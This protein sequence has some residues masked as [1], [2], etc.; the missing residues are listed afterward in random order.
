MPEPM[1]RP[2]PSKRNGSRRRGLAIIGAIVLLGA[3]GYAVYWFL[4]LAHYEST[5]DAYVS[6]DVLTVTPLEDGTVQAVHVDDTQR[7]KRGQLLVELDDARPKIEM[8]AARANL[9][10]TVRD[11]R[12]TFAKAD[13]LR[14]LIKQRQVQVDRAQA[15]YK[16]RADL[17]ADGAVAGEDIA[18]AKDDLAELKAQLAVAREQLNSTLAQL[19]GTGVADNPQVLAAASRVRDAALSLA[20]MRIIAP[21]DGTVAQRSVEIGQHV[22]AGEP[23]MAVVPLQSVWVDANFKE[24]Q[25]AD[26][27]VGQPVELESDVYGGDVTFHGRVAGFSAGSGSAFALLPPQNASG[28]WIKIVQRLP[29]RIALDPKEVEKHPLRIGLSMSANVDVAD[30]SGPVISDRVRDGTPEIKPRDALAPDVEAMI[31]ETIS[32]NAGDGPH[33]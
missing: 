16:R 17:G 30:T 20:H 12:A 25:L 6:G 4:F 2:A 31:A 9:A 11:V 21:V 15:D 10:R 33:K 29:V 19:G 23:L 7:V 1:D 3:I 13:E 5:N 22:K 8:E 24:V 18:H 26:M 27:R 14:A 32:A 28:N